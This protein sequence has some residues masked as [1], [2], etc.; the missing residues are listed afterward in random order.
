MFRI[1]AEWFGQNL[2]V[3]LICTDLALYFAGLMTGL[4]I[5][6]R[7]TVTYVMLIMIA[8]YLFAVLA[9]ICGIFVVETFAVYLG[10]IAALMFAGLLT[11]LI[12]REIKKQ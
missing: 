4:K 11:S 8:V 9:S 12:Y 7:K 2:S 6:R 1:F 10:A 3:P 5:Y